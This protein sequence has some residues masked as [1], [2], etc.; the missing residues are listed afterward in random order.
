VIGTT[1]Y[2]YTRAT[3]KTRTEISR[4]TT[5]DA[6][7]ASRPT[8]FLIHGFLDSTNKQ[9]WIDMKNALLDAVRNCI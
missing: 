7:S 8:K 1:F 4:Y 3:R 6:W 2:L 9:W 5:L